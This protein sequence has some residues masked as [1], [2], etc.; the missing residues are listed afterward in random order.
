[1]QETQLAIVIPYYKKR[2]FRELLLALKAQS[3]QSFHVYIGDDCAP[4]DARDLVAEVGENLSIQYCRFDSRLGNISLAGHWN[5]CLALIRD[6][7]WIWVLPDDDLPSPNCVAE[8][9][10][11]LRAGLA[12]GV[13][14]FAFPVQVINAAGQTVSAGRSFSG[15][16]GNYDFYLGQLKGETGGSTLGENIFRRD[17]LVGRGGFVEFPKGW[18]SDHATLIRA[19]AGA[20]IACLSGA[21]F[22]FRQSGL[23]IS[24]KDD[25]GG[26]K[27]SARVL[28]ARWLKRNEGLF[29]KPP[30]QAF[31]RYFYWKGEFYAVHVWQ[32]SAALAWQL[33]RLRWVCMRSLNVLALVKLFATRRRA[34]SQGVQL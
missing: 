12:A 24:S 30:D 9:M 25:D 3:D 19:S 22:G 32:F 6:E 33:L 10:T 17:A 29:S 1:M 14:V 16:V 11:A 18:G 8:F 5:R 26:Q 27:M 4:E 28:F 20:K 23:N 21:R 7:P 2:Y 34:R 15:P 13:N 31:Y